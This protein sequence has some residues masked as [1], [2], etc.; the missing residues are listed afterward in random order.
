MKE[1][2][3]GA[4]VPVALGLAAAGVYHFVRGT[5][6]FNRVRFAKQHNAIEKY[7]EAHF[8]G[9][10]YAPIQ[11]CEHGWITVISTAGGSRITLY[12]TKT[13]DGTYLFRES[14]D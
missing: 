4:W 8:P 1:K 10:T 2:K 13:D 12:I 9:A 6:A 5:G 14:R 11:S 3:S 7:I